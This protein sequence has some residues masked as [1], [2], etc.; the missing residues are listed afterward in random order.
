MEV[1]VV[2]ARLLEVRE[3]QLE[4]ESLPVGNNARPDSK[5][6][7]V[8]LEKQMMTKTTLKESKKN[9]AYGRQSISRPM[10]IVAP[11]PQ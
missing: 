6:T 1:V 5:V 9:P 11:I 2:M 4:K 10:R 7:F 3:E 8:V